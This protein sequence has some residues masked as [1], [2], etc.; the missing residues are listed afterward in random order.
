MGIETAAWIP[1]SL[2]GCRLRIT[3]DFPSDVVKDGTTYT[4]P[5]RYSIRK[6]EIVACCPVH[7][8]WTSEMP[9]VSVFSETAPPPGGDVNMSIMPLGPFPVYPLRPYLYYP[10][11]NPTAAEMLYTHLSMHRGHTH[12]LSCGCAAYLH[13]DSES[14]WSYR[15][16]PWHS[17]QCDRHQ[18][19]T[20]DMKQAK[21][22]QEAQDANGGQIGI[23]GVAMT[24][25][26]TPEGVGTVYNRS[27]RLGRLPATAVPA[28]APSTSPSDRLSGVWAK[29]ERANKHIGDLNAF[30]D[31]L[32]FPRLSVLSCG[33]GE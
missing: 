32:Y 28:N 8:R 10:I 5:A 21:A 29:I 25:T 22:D 2:C 6:I 12:F 15:L 26:T 24:T 33:Q 31:S 4:H 1:P 9:D 16:H 23:L 3:A 11:P 20:I 30:V 27:V 17:R 18:G 13:C 19:D 7:Q 14:N